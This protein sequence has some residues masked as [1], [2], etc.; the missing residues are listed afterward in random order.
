MI[1]FHLT[2]IDIKLKI[3]LNQLHLANVIKFNIKVIEI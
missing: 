3:Y 2:L 1:K